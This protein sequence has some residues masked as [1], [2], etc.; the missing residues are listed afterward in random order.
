MSTTADAIVFAIWLKN[1]SVVEI[2][3]GEESKKEK[4]NRSWIQARRRDNAVAQSELPLSSTHDRDGAD[5]VLFQE[6]ESWYDASK[7]AKG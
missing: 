5:D 1:G 7:A 6:Q 4:S 2:R 3:K